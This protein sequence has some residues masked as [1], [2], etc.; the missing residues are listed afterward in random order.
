VPERCQYPM[1]FVLLG[2]ALSEKQVPQVDGNT[3]EARGLLEALESVDM[4][5]RQARY[6][7]ALRPDIH[8]VL[9][10]KAPPNI[11]PNLPAQKIPMTPTL[12]AESRIVRRVGETAT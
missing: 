9:N 4:R 10:S 11:T 5:P 12:S 3:E 1:F 2:F 7:A 8:C 6:Q